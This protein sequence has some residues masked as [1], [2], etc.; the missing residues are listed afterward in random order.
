MDHYR[1]T[2][3]CHGSDIPKGKRLNRRSTIDLEAI[4]ERIMPSGKRFA[5]ELRGDRG[6]GNP[7]APIPKGS[8]DSLLSRQPSNQRQTVFRCSEEARPGIVCCQ[9]RSGA[10]SPH[11]REQDLR[12]CANLRVAFVGIGDV[13]VFTADDDAL[14]GCAPCIKI[15]IGS[16]QISA[17]PVHALSDGSVATTQVETIR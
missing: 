4:E 11:L 8:E 5:N 10:Q 16:L 1:A 6:K 14:I 9:S 17:S 15:G 13:F 7:V 12:L 3:G 2:L